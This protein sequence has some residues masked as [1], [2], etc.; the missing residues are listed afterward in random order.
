MEDNKSEKKTV[1]IYAVVLFTSAFI[2]L[3][4]TAY[5]QIKFNKNIDDY[6]NQI[7]SEVKEKDSFKMNLNQA[8]EN[9]KKLSE[10]I[11]S[12]KEELNKLNSQILELK[13]QLSDALTKTNNISNIYELVLQA[14]NEYDKGNIIE[15]AGILYGITDISKMSNSL[16]DRYKLLV[17][18]TYRSAAYKLYLQGYN[19]YIKGNYT[20]AIYR[21]QQSYNLASSEYYSDDCIF[22]IGYSELKLGDNSKAREQFEI[23]LST[24]PNSSFAKE[25]RETLARIN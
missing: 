11:K 20:E 21:L 8:L 1:W 22:F 7:S 3:L 6:R 25:A 5:S 24:F 23:L 13:K 18:K 10:E 17:D 15:S 9:N 19:H 14:Q 16:Q 12:S 2:V 4:L